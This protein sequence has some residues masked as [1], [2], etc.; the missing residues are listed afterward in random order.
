MHDE[1][2]NPR[3]ADEHAI[4]KDNSPPLAQP[5][6]ASRAG[7][8]L[9]HALDIFQLHVKDAICADFGCNIGVSRMCFCAPARVK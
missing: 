5:T 7:L 2:K 6:L 3:G 9:Q 1:E 8:K 4:E